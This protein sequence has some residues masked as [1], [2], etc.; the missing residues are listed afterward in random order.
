MELYD[1]KNNK[2]SKAVSNLNI[3]SFWN[4]KTIKIVGKIDQKTEF[5]SVKIIFY[6][7]SIGRKISI[8]YGD[9]KASHICFN[10]RN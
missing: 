9:E 1:D 10:L 4:K 2:I 5:Q 7:F 6:G 3:F 8:L